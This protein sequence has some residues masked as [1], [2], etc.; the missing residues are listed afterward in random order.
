MTGNKD[1]LVYLCLSIT[2]QSNVIRSVVKSLCGSL[3]VT[4]TLPGHSL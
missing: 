3:E 2:K 1:L 4:D